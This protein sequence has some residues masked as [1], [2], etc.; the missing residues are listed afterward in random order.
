MAEFADKVKETLSEARNVY[1]ERNAVYK[2][3]FRNVGEVIAALFPNGVVLKTAEDFTRWHIF[4]L[5]IVKLTRYTQNYEQGG[6]E[7]SIKD[8]IVYLGILNGLDDEKRAALSADPQE[9]FQP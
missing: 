4:E 7:D 9:P 1:D 2:D 8:R 3:N 5:E 6:H